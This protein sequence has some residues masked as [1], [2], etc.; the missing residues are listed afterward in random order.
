MTAACNFDLSELGANLGA[1]DTLIQC[2][3]SLLLARI[4]TSKIVSK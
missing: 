2:S 1:I 4:A 3:A